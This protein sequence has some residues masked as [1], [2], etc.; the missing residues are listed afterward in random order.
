MREKEI[1]LIVPDNILF[2]D[3]CSEGRIL[4]YFLKIQR[5]KGY[6]NKDTYFINQLRNTMKSIEYKMQEKLNGLI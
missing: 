6:D 4:D 1:P 2:A 5:I 3:E